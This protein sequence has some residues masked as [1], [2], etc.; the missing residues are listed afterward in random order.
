MDSD[1]GNLAPHPPILYF[2]YDASN[3]SYRRDLCDKMPECSEDI[4]RR[5]DAQAKALVTFDN[6]SRAADVLS[7][8]YLSGW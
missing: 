3:G 7:T 2:I 1:Q 8:C 5:F 4:R 6:V